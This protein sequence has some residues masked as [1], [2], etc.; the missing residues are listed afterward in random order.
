MNL[1]RTVRVLIALLKAGRVA[2]HILLEDVKRPR[3]GRTGQ[4][5]ESPPQQWHF[6]EAL[7]AQG[8]VITSRRN[9]TLKEDPCMWDLYSYRPVLKTLS[10]RVIRY[11]STAGQRYYNKEQAVKCSQIRRK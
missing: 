6:P 10:F 2:Y 4:S 8:S 3:L 5:H 9:S 7:L 1:S 11:I